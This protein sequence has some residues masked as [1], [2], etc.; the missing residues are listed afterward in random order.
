[1]KYGYCPPKPQKIS[2]KKSTDK[3]TTVKKALS[4]SFK[5]TKKIKLNIVDSKSSLKTKTP[6]SS[7]MD[8]NKTKRLNEEF[9]NVLD[10][11]A[12][13]MTRQGEGF[14]AKAYREASEAI[15]NY[16]TDI[17]DPEQ[18]KGVKY[19]GKTIMDKLKEYVKTG[20][21]VLERERKNP[22]NLLTKVYGIGPKKAK[23]FIEKG[24]T[25]IQDLRD[26]EDLL[27]KNMMIYMKY[28]DD[29]ES[30][31]PLEEIDEYDKILKRIFNEST[32]PGSTMEIVGSYR[33]GAKTSGDIDIII[34]NDKNNNKILDMFLDNL[35][36][37]KIVIEILSKGKTKSLTVGQIPGKRP[38]RL[39]FMYT[40][41][42]EYSFATLYFTGSKAFNTVQ[43]QR[44]LDLGYTLMS[45]DFIIWRA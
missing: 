11:L 31:I 18:L 44:A 43:R 24:I 41:P 32:P 45:M 36:K 40:P 19:I 21:R 5:K 38:R 28:F 26:N 16:N 8:K 22:L 10:E 14:R 15:T 2:S 42:M 4:K 39:D 27:T 37:D 30:R 13:I 34:T 29:I 9:V 12:T 6:V 17:T 33:R 7:S 23:E 3:K 35:V 20:T 1:M 25:T